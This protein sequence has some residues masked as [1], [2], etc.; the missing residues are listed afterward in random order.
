MEVMKEELKELEDK[1]SEEEE[2]H[3][4]EIKRLEESKKRQ[5]QLWIDEY[6]KAQR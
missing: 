4:E 5:L 3:K 1:E 2:K 6:Q